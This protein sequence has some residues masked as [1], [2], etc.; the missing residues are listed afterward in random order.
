MTEMKED[1]T[2][3]SQI[4][5]TAH[6]AASEAFNVSSIISKNISSLNER[7]TSALNEDQ[8]TPSMVRDLAE[9]VLNKNIILNPDEIKSLADSIQSIVGSLTDS[10]QILKDT[11][12]DLKQ[13]EELRNNASEAK[14]YAIAQDT[15]VGNVIVLLSEAEVAAESAEAAIKNVEIDISMATK[16]LEDVYNAVEDAEDAA[17]NSTIEISRLDARLT[18]L[19]TLVAKNEF[20]LTQEI[21]EE[22]KHVEVEAKETKQKTEM[23]IEDFEEASESLRLRSDQSEDG[24]A[25]AKSLLQRASGL[26]ADTTTKF[27]DISGMEGVYLDNEKTLADLASEVEALTRQMEIHFNEIQIKSQTYNRCSA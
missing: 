7:I 9:S 18:E 23:L 21:S 27:K 17:D 3:A 24:I 26:A 19:Q 12:K 15:L 5:K 25:R 11:A 22:V 2:L 16:D 14:N 4:A 1:A 8:S 6:D 20:I 13:A 10:D